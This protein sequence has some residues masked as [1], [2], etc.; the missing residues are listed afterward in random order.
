MN[1]RNSL[2]RCFLLIFA[3][4]FMSNS[5]VSDITERA[6]DM[7]NHGEFKQAAMLLRPEAE[8]G[9]P[10]ASFLAAQLFFDGHGVI[11]SKEQGYKYL[12]SAAD[13]GSVDAVSFLALK[14]EEEGDVKGAVAA[15]ERF[16]DAYPDVFKSYESPLALPLGLYYRDRYG[17]LGMNKN[18]GTRKAWETIRST[19]AG[20]ND[21]RTTPRP[22]IESLMLL[23]DTDLAGL[24]DYFMQHTD[25]FMACDVIVPY[26]TDMEKNP[27]ALDVDMLEQMATKGNPLACVAA[28][29]WYF[30][31]KPLEVAI[32]NT[33]RFMEKA[34]EKGGPFYDFWKK[35]Y[36]KYYLPGDVIDGKL[37]FLTDPTGKIPMVA[38]SSQYIFQIPRLCDFHENNTNW[39]YP[40]KE[41]L[42]ELTE[43]ARKANFKD[44]KF[45]DSYLTS[46]STSK[47][48]STERACLVTEIA[49]GPVYYKFSKYGSS[50][51]INV[52]S[53]VNSD[54]YTKVE[55]LYWWNNQNPCPEKTPFNQNAVIK[56]DGKDYPLI[57]WSYASTPMHLE[58]QYY[59]ARMT[60]YFERIPDDWS[61]ISMDMPGCWSIPSLIH[62]DYTQYE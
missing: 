62:E 42:K 54:I 13:K 15:L 26:L 6:K 49:D 8:K 44:H 28:A 55:L 10:E 35:C 51:V 24:A 19:Q 40:S 21:I 1:L 37:V 38:S 30:D 29:E 61:R 5:E 16:R 45:A 50:P 22:W 17:N 56:C 39:R 60:L 12:Q 27:D 53:V 47:K 9:D 2:F 18:D 14:R 7:I 25:F 43:V 3:L 4:G 33:R 48:N 52:K 11:K 58:G 23:H 59:T 34:G 32:S 46:R 20:M 36:D 57:R 41:E 31:N